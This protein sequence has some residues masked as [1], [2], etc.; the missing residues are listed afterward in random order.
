MG[1]EKPN[2]GVYYQ[3]I[4]NL[5]SRVTCSATEFTSE[6][7]YLVFLSSEVMWSDG[8]SYSCVYGLRDVASHNTAL[9]IWT[10]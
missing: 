5:L 2:W 4:F 9:S 10:G 7:K 1:Q 6:S 8:T 3:P